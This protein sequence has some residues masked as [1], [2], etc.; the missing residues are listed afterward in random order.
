MDYNTVLGLIIYAVG[1]A[2][3]VGIDET[4]GFTQDSLD[5]RRQSSTMRSHRLLLYVAQVCKNKSCATC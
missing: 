5:R 3:T 2:R 1:R 4:I